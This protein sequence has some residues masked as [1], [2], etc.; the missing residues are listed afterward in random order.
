MAAK[1]ERI[2]KVPLRTWLLGTPKQRQRAWAKFQ[3]Q[4]R[5]KAS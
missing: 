2:T 4:Q 5:K 3:R 1:L